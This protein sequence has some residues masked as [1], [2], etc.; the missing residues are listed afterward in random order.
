MTRFYMENWLS[1]AAGIYLLGMILYGHH[2]GFIRLA[3]SL[4]AVLVSLTIVRIALP[5][6]TGYLKENTKI[7]QAISENVKKSIGLETG[8]NA[9]WLNQG[10]PAAQRSL[11]EDLELPQNIKAALIENNNNEMY[12]VLG[13]Q[14]FTDYIGSYLA[15]LIL[16]SLAVVLLFSGVYLAIRLVMHWLDIIARLPIL[17]GIN[18]LAGALLGGAEGLI[19]LWLAC[20]V[21]TAFSGTDWGILAIRQ[22]EMSK[23]LS[24]L[25]RHNFVNLIV[26]QVLQGMP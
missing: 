11:I 15:D 6:V 7:Q 3:V 17:S 8:E 2:R 20:L 14:A 10:A 9:A 22:I 18:K 19:F 13:V 25:Y 12:Q 16:N 26:L 1:A 23:W 21:I 5:S 24:F 4:L